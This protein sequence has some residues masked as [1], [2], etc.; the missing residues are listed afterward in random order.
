MQTSRTPA[1]Y[2]AQAETLIHSSAPF[3][4][5]AEA[6][7]RALVS[8]AQIA[9]GN[10]QRKSAVPAG[11]VDWLRRGKASGWKGERRDM[12]DQGG[13]AYP[14]ST[15]GFFTPTEFSDVC[16]AALKAVDDLFDPDVTSILTSNGGGPWSH[17]LADD[18]E[19]AAQQINQNQPSNVGDIPI[20]SLQFPTAPTWRSGG[21]KISIEEAQDS[22]VDLLSFLTS[23]FA[24]RFQRGFS[25]TLVTKLL[26]VANVAVTAIGAEAAGQTMPGGADQSGAESLSSDDLAALIGACDPAYLANASWL[27]NETT[28][29]RLLGLR[30]TPMGLLVFPPHRDPETGDFLIFNRPVKICPS[31]PNIGTSGSPATGNIPVLFGD[32]KRLCIRKVRGGDYVTQSCRNLRGER[33]D[34]FRKFCAGRLGHPVVRRDSE[35][36]EPVHRA[37]EL[38][39]RG[40]RSWQKLSYERSGRVPG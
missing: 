9:A 1:D 38:G 2:L 24:V 26:A 22:G 10:G 17:P 36:P 25:P 18:T 40:G 7:V 3:S 39:L 30:S 35:H 4:K 5:D 27:M 29:G 16:W 21:L 20:S 31:M 15:T 33:V 19:D 14:G 23:S 13:G 34:F 11:F 12:G 8:L 6:R 37:T 28:L 32:L